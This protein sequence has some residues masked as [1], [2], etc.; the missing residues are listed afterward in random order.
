MLSLLDRQAHD[1]EEKVKIKTADLLDE[2]RKSDSLLAEILPQSIIQRLR[3]KEPITAE[4]F[5]S[6]SILFSDIPAF[7]ILLQ[8][9][10]PIELISILNDTHSEFDG[11]V[12]DFN[13]YKVETIGD[14]YMI[15]SGVPLP[16]EDH[17][18]ELCQLSLALLEAPL[19]FQ[20]AHDVVLTARTGINSE[21]SALP[22]SSPPRP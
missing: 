16:N 4:S 21:A 13:A 20:A 1:L 10:T 22:R 11:V 15:S 3:N 12:H 2:M 17:A 5:S 8:R 14:C 18:G 19:T 6:V 7:A 9:C